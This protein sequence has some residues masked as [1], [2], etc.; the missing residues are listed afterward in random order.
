MALIELLLIVLGSMAA[1]RP[2]SLQYARQQ[3]APEPWNQP[4]FV[5][6]NYVITAVWALAFLVMVVAELG[7]RYF[8]GLSPRV[9]IMVVILALI[10]AMKFTGWYPDR[11]KWWSDTWVSKYPRGHE[12]TERNCCWTS[13]RSA[14]LGTHGSC[15]WWG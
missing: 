12:A 2:F 3:V 6:T 14:Y 9:G 4:E 15:R 13:P 10:G 11:E 7:L 1:M 8:P 5:R